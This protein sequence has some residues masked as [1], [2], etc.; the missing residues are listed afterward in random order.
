MSKSFLASNPGG[1][2]HEAI[3]SNAI[4]GMLAHLHEPK[5]T[6]VFQGKIL[7]VGHEPEAQYPMDTFIRAFDPYRRL[8]SS[9]KNFTYVLLGT[10]A[11][12]DETRS[13]YHDAVRRRLK[14]EIRLLLKDAGVE[15]WDG[16]G[17]LALSSDTVDIAQRLVDSFPNDIGI[18][19]VT[20]TPQGEVDFDWDVDDET[21]LTV[22][23]GPSNEI[24]FTGLFQNARL[25]GSE[26]W[27]NVLPE[28]VNCCFE[29]LRQLQK[30]Q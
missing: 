12:Q 16:E 26:P 5:Q 1:F 29:R 10:H 3:I 15:N 8:G 13:G 7:S 17:A 9:E 22:S 4:P 23:V 2:D 14:N 20:A 24:A 18:P 21:M 6:Q 30:N 11:P 25:R 19:E 27:A 28:F